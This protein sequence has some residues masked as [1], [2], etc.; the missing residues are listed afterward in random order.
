MPQYI[1]LSSV[2]CI[3]KQYLTSLHFDYMWFYYSCPH[4]HP[5]L[6]TLTSMLANN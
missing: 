2:H 4:F 6:S 3:Y 5:P 1:I